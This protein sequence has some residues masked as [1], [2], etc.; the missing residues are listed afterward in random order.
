MMLKLQYKSSQIKSWLHKQ[1][2]VQI[3]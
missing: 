1:I 3:R 2:W